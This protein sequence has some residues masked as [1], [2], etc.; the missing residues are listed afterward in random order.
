MLVLW[1]LVCGASSLLF[2]IAGWQ[3]FVVGELRVLRPLVAP[4]ERF[5]NA[6]SS[7]YRDPTT[8]WPARVLGATFLLFGLF[9]VAAAILPWVAW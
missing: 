4:L 9:G 3:G 5:R 7:D 1:S 2:L 8:G 6:V